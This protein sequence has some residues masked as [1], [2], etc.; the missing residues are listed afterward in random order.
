MVDKV[1]K[2]IDVNIRIFVVLLIFISVVFKV[3]NFDQLLDYFGI[4]TM[5]VSILNG[6][7]VKFFWKKFDIQ[8]TPKL[9][10]DYDVTI[11][12]YEDGK[13]HQKE[14]KASIKQ[15]FLKIDINLETNEMYSHSII[16]SI[17]PENEGYVL[18]YIYETEPRSEYSDQNP[19]QRGSCRFY[20][21]SV[22]KIEKFSGIYWT[23][24]QRK[25]DIE[26]SKKIN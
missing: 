7:Y 14:C 16:S 10:G 11:T 6:L 24:K 25:G 17:L 15:T 3:G 19:K 22:D 23:D 1:N 12:Y 20:I 26:F 8:K 2:L 4:V 21:E 13:Q 18:Y 5:I 9:Y